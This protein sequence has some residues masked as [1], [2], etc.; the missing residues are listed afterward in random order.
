MECVKQ[1]GKAMDYLRRKKCPFIC[2]F[3]VVDGVSCVRCRASASER[4]ISHIRKGY[5]LALV[6]LVSAEEVN[7]A[8]AERREAMERRTCRL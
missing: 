4:E 7:A 8:H 5:P 6:E 2:D 1:T 3:V